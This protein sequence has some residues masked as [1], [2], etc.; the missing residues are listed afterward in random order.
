MKLT[1]AMALL[2]GLSVLA[3]CGAD[4]EPIQ[5]SLNA[6]IGISPSGI[7]PRL[8]IGLGKGPLS[9]GLNL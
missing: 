5:P 3:A 9:I 6:G 8:G 2:L 4:G 1:R 7:S